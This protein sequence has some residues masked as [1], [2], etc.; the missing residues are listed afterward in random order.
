[1]VPSAASAVEREASEASEG[2]QLAG[3]A[4][5]LRVDVA[6]D[7]VHPEVSHGET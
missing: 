7:M 6:W 1:M 3:R 4:S 2:F 5:L